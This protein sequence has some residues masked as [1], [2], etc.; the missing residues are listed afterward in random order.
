ME[1]ADICIVGGGIA[2]ASVAY[3]VAPH[4][5]VLLLEREPHF[6]YHSSG[7]SA[8]LYTPQYGSVVVR[9]LTAASGLFVHEP[10]P[11]FASVPLLT[12]RGHL[13]IGAADEHAALARHESLAAATGATLERLSS[14]AARALVPSL[15]PA[16]VGWGLYDRSAMDLD[17]EALL[18]GF[19]RS[20][21]GHGAHIATAHEVLE[22]TPDGGRWRIRT[23]GLEVRAGILVNAAGAWADEF[24]ARAGIAP[25]GLVPRRRTAFIFDA[26]EAVDFARWPM[27]SDAEERFYFKP[28]AGRLLGSLGEEVASAPCDAQPDDLDVATAVDRI[29]QAVDFAVRRVS[30]S[31]TGLRTFAADRDPVSG[32]EPGGGGFYWHAAFGGYGIQTAAALGAFAAATLLGRELPA[33]LTERGLRPAQLAPQRLRN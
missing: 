18:Q 2:G 6:A 22:V 32:F 14:A 17:V 29:E 8:A 10:P 24:A 27:V 5:R 1:T 21:R 16:A 13:T 23:P 4:A 15:R 26:P 28:D 3:H 11:G 20:A 9:L 7:R 33:T 12:E 25:L 19:L 31:W 30:R